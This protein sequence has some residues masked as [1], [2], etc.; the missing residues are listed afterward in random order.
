MTSS[1]SN[2]FGTKLLNWHAS[3]D[4]KL[5]W[6]ASNDPYKI[7]LSEIIMQQT[8]VA[9]GTPYYLKFVESFPTIID[10]AN[11]EED[12]VMKLWQGLGYYSRAR[13]LHFTAKVVRDKYDGI[14]PTEYKEVLALKGIGKYTAAA[15]VSFA[16]GQ[17][18]PVVDGNVIRLIARYFGLTSAVDSTETLKKINEL[19]IKLIKGND[20][21]DY[22]QAIMDFGA[23][24]C[25][26]KSPN[27]IDCPFNNDCRAYSTEQVDSIPYKAKKIKKRTRHLHYL[28]ITDADNKLII[29]HRTGKDIWKHLYDFPSLELT[30]NKTLTIDE[31]QNF[32]S[33]LINKKIINFKSATKSYKHI[34]THQ[35]IYGQFYNIQINK[36]PLETEHYILISE[37]ELNNFALPVLILNYLSDKANWSLF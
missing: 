19:A 20:P 15:I 36:F 3:I 27:C 32:I 14:F 4:R 8:R 30:T 18:Y 16:Y 12:K 31:C 25:S 35:T 7:W 6:K 17:E 34:L 13:N 22:N 28:Y 2:S 10:L 26:P 24:M 9:Q 5:P 21:G 33:K 11:A 1:S 23:L 29:N 37:N